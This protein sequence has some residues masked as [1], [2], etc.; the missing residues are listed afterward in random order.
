MVSEQKTKRIH[1]T[2]SG[3]IPS[4]FHLDSVLKK[5]AGK[6]VHLC[7]LL[8]G[9]KKS[10]GNVRHASAP[11]TPWFLH[12]PVEGSVI[13]IDRKW[14]IS[15]MVLVCRLPSH[16]CQYFP[17]LQKVIEYI[18]VFAA[19]EMVSKQKKGFMQKI[20]GR[21]PSAF[22]LDSVLKKKT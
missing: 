5:K 7:S 9:H 4:A 2:Y 12:D 15:V 19:F 20:N 1:A 22:H 17:D 14:R 21:I 10:H 18:N 13:L 6:F 16:L 3:R 8:L 11:I